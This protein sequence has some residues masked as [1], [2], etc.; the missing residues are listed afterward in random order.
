[1]TIYNHTVQNFDVQLPMKYSRDKE[2][3][4]INTKFILSL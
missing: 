4:E 2:K 1:M 3:I